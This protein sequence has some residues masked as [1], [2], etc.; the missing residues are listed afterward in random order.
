MDRQ[1]EIINKIREVA[2]ST[3]PK[4]GRMFLFGSQARGDARKDSDWDI[5]IL[6]DKHKIVND[7]FDK[8]AYPV[9]ELGWK[10]GIEINPLIYT[11]TDWEKRSFT[12]FYKNIQKDGIELW[13]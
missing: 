8:V 9:V 5:L 11:Y 2:H 12:L 13:H 1:A 7:D 4:G 10:L 6:L 3:I